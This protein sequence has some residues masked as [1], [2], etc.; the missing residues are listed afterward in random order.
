MSV[1]SPIISRL[2]RIALLTPPGSPKKFPFGLLVK[3]LP[4]QARS[5][6]LSRK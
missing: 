5:P 1:A 3:K 4:P 2:P 6:S